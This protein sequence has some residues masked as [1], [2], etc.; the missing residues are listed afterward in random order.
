MAYVKAI[1]PL[2]LVYNGT[3]ARYLQRDGARFADEINRRGDI[4]VKLI[5]DDGSGFPKPKS[6][7]LDTA[8]WKDWTSSQY[9]AE[10]H[11]D[12]ILL[13]SKGTDCLLSLFGLK[14]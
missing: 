5:I 4:G 10:T 8:L 12:L 6:P 13:T 1:F 3:E 14:L 2:P 7:L 9:W 11:A